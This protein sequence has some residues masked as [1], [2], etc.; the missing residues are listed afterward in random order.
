MRLLIMLIFLF[1]VLSIAGEVPEFKSGDLIFQGAGTGSF[2]KAITDATSQND[3]ISFVHVGIIEAGDTDLYVVEASP[4]NGVRKI[5]LVEFISESQKTKSG[6]LV[7][8]KRLKFDFPVEAMLKRVYS[9]LNE[10]YD[11]WYLP[12]NGKMYCS[13]LVYETYLDTDGDHIFQSQ[14]MNFRDNRGE[15]PEFWESLFNKLGMEVPEG[16]LG[17]NPNDLFRDDNLIEIYRFF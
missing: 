7:I 15:I 17:T 16:V 3:S 11:W 14:P 4:E 9:H 13:E 1:S 8:V 12:D 6:P 2:S 10:P 5:Q